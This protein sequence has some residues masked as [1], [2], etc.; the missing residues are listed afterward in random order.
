MGTVEKRL[1]TEHI[2]LMKAVIILAKQN[3]HVFLIKYIS[4]NTIGQTLKWWDD[5]FDRDSE[6]QEKKRETS[7]FEINKKSFFLCFGVCIKSPL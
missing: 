2:C 5:I 4:Q 6:S 7:L 3:V 1:L